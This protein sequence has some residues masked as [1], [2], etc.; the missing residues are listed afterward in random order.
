MFKPDLRLEGTTLGILVV[1]LMLA[2]CSDAGWKAGLAARPNATTTG[3]NKIV[4][5][6]DSMTQGDEG[7]T[8]TAAYPS[9]LLTAI[10]PTIVN[11][12][13]GGQTS[14]QIGVRQGGVAS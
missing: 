9:L 1:S 13:I 10:G 4:C 14:T 2:G 3:S 7:I 12:G 5:W 11:E 8:D 6:G